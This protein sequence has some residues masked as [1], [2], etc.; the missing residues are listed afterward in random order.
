MGAAWTGPQKRAEILKFCKQRALPA[1]ARRTYG[2][3]WNT[4]RLAWSG[5]ESRLGFGE[6]LMD[7]FATANKAIREEHPLPTFKGS[8]D[9]YNYDQSVLLA[10]G[11]K[12]DPR[13]VLQGYSAYTPE[14]ARMDE[15]H[16]R[17]SKAPDWIIFDL[18]TII[19]R[20]PALDDGM[21]WSAILDNYN[22]TSSDGHYVFLHKKQTMLPKSDFVDVLDQRCDAGKTI[23]LP[24]T[25]GP[26]FAEIDLKPTLAGKVAAALINPPQLWMVI[27]LKD[28]TSKRFRVVSEMMQTDFLI[29]PFV[30]DTNDFAAFMAHRA[31]VQEGDTVRS[32]S[33]T[34][35]Y[36]RSIYWSG[37]YRLKLKRYVG[38]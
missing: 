25:S 1:Y 37:T 24:E 9:I 34:S 12:W 33:I 21:S 13:P 30:G 3:T 28:G 19:G 6:S 27:G 8:A 31:S 32:I 2:S 29:S 10:S 18:Q 11:N 17:G 26:L 15:Q 16:L 36:G 38:Q 5:I 4:Y 20:L 7:Q 23:F 22:F 14:L 35:A